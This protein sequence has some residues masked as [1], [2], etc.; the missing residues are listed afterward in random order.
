MEVAFHL[1]N[2]FDKAAAPHTRNSYHPLI[3][4][5]FDKYLTTSSNF[6]AL[7]KYAPDICAWTTLNYPSAAVH[8]ID[9]THIIWPHGSRGVLKAFTA[10][11]AAAVLRNVHATHTHY[12]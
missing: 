1:G 8:Y 6:S 2:S 4:F 10:A 3:A 7:P 11:A 5:P 9:Y 12:M